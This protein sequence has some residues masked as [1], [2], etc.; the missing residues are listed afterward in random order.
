[1]IHRGPARLAA[2]PFAA[3]LALGLAGCVTLFPKEKPAPLYRFSTSFQAAQAAPGPRFAVRSGV[4]DFDPAS[5]GDRILTVDGDQVA[6]VGDARWDVAAVQQFEAALAK[7]FD[8]T[9]GPA[10][11]VGSGHPGKALYRLKVA[12]TQFEARYD[13]GPTAPPTIVVK[14]TATLDKEV[15]STLVGVKDFSAEVPASDNRVAPMVSA[16]GAAT[17]KVIGDLVAW[18]DQAPPS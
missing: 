10:R 15:D 9:G 1:M 4:V 11:L 12:V 16:Y 3:A 14:A 13:H 17:S 7:G 18:V 5:E 2:L 6:Y 8:E